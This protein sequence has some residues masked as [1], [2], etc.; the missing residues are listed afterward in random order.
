MTSKHQLLRMVAVAL[1]M[2]AIAY[3]SSAQTSEVGGRVIG[4]SGDP[5]R[6]ARVYALST[7]SP[8]PG[9]H[10]EVL[11]D[12]D[13]EF[14]LSNV[15]AGQHEI[16]AY[17]PEI[18]YPD[19]LF[20]VFQTAPVPSIKLKNGEAIHGIEIQLGPKP[21]TLTG[22]VVDEHSHKPLPAASVIL[23]WVERPE[24]YIE[25]SV[26]QNGR[27]T[28]SVPLHALLITVSCSGYRTWKSTPTTVS[29]GETYHL[30][31]AMTK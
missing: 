26:D 24:Y 22:E 4:P 16:H 1:S 3:R 8:S 25:S 13:G 10:V 12:P 9:R 18:G 30:V 19:N 31:A 28:F 14:L 29:S 6:E 17:A 7:E 5:I 11:T 21:G 20:A 2:H 23:R 15:R 27:F